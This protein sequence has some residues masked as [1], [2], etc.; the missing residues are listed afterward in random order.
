MTRRWSI[1]WVILIGL[2][3]LGWLYL[4]STQLMS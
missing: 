2:F 1:L 3:L 4:H